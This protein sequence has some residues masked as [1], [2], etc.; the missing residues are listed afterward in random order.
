[1]LGEMQDASEPG[2]HGQLGETEALLPWYAAGRLRRRD[3]RRIEEALRSDAAL[4]QE[5]VRVREE[6]VETIRLNEMLGAPS[7]RAMDKLMA[8]I[9]AE[10]VARKP[11]RLRAV[12][13]WFANSIASFSPR[14]LALGASLAALAIVLQG[15]ML[16]GMLTNKSG[17]TVPG[18]ARPHGTFAMIRFT[19]Q[20]NAAEITDFLQNY[21]ATVVDGPK[22]GGVYRVRV[23]VAALAKEE[24]GRIVS[25]MRKERI[26]EFAAAEPSD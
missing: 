20:A 6:L 25:R 16:L 15:S 22:P 14:T 3:R 10:E 5:A 11:R 13:Q 17:D 12:G 8:A 23:A 4:A 26:V 7:A 21:Q 9:D 1:M 18:A 19:R 24:L 2:G